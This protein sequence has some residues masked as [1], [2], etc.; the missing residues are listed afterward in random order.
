MNG[1]LLLT[2][3]II[4]FRN[5]YPELIAQWERQIN[6]GNPHPDLYFCMTLLDD[7]SYLNAYLRSIEYRIDFAINAYITLSNW[8]REFIG[9]GYDHNLALELANRELRLTCKALN[10]SETVTEDPKAKVYHNILA[11]AHLGPF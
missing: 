1:T 11:H 4:E 10:D 9:S 8:Q 7:Y 3:A 6:S 5:S 2:G